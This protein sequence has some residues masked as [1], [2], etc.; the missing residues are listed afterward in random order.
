MNRISVK[1]VVASAVATLLAGIAFGQQP[2]TLSLPAATTS[3]P[4][5]RYEVAVNLLTAEAAKVRGTYL[6]VGVE[7][8]GAALR[9]QLKLPDGVGLVV[10]YVDEK[11]PSQGLIRTHDVLEK[12]DDQLMV[13]AEQLVTLVRLRKPGAAARVT[14]IREAQPTVVEVKLGENDVPP[15]GWLS[16]AGQPG[17]EALAIHDG[18]L[19]VQRPLGNWLLQSAGPATAATTQP[20]AVDRATL[21]RRLSLD[22]RGTLPT[23][24]EVTDFV[25]DKAENAVQKLVDH[26]LSEP[27]SM[28]TWVVDTAVAAAPAAVPEAQRGVAYVT[29]LIT[30]ADA[31]AR[32][33][34]AG[35]VTIDDGQTMM[36]IQPGKDGATELTVV[37]RATGQVTFKGPIATD[38][39]WRQVPEDVR[40]KFEAWKGALERK[41]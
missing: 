41:P 23:P 4:S 6:G 39:Q 9:S 25:N 16:T 11:G 10:N 33:T 37:D 18:N 28:Q 24:Q 30:D 1:G 19:I 27:R 8:P 34:S 2:N 31:V 13:N 38:D 7:S 17:S 5:A 40:R 15:L 29:G 3:D 21:I 14:L 12:L 32:A 26:L 35:P 20:A 22:L 36:W